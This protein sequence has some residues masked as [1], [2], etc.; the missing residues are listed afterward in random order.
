[1]EKLL[2]ENENESEAILEILEMIGKNRG[3]YVLRRKDRPK[4]SFKYYTYR[5]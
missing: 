2:N 5:F 1:M 4:K 3:C